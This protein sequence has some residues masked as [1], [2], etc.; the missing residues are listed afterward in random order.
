MRLIRAMLDAA[1]ANADTIT[2]DDILRY[3]ESIAEAS[4]GIFGIGKV[5]KEERATIAQIA[6][7]LKQRG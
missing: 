3:C 6:A 7:G 2:A 1:P 5:S 4:G